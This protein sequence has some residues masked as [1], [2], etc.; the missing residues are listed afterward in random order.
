[1]DESALFTI[2]VPMLDPLPLD[3]AIFDIGSSRR[4]GHRG[5]GTPADVVS[6][7]FRTILRAVLLGHADPLSI[8]QSFSRRFSGG[9]PRRGVG[10]EW[11]SS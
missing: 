7:L 5:T 2:A 11:R 10:R 3:T 1:M 9:P 8:P 6:C 4:R